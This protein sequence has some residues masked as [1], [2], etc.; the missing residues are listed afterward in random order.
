MAIISIK[1]NNISNI[2]HTRKIGVVCHDAGGAE[3]LSS[4][5]KQNNINSN[6]C[7]DGPAIDIF[8]KIGNI[9]VNNLE[10]VINNSDLILCGTSW[11]SD[12]EWNAIYKANKVRK[13]ISIIDHWVNYRGRYMRNGLI[14][15]PTEIWV[16]DSYAYKIATEIFPSI[17]IKKIINPY[18]LDIKIDWHNLKNMNKINDSKNDVLFISDNI[19]NSLQK[20]YGN[21][22]YWGYTDSDSFSF[23]MS[24]IEKIHP[25][26]TNVSI[27]LHPSEN[28][29]NYTWAL[30]KYTP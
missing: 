15:Y 18:L 11:Q 13:T 10:A 7:L 28:V 19:K 20:Q 17:V 24:H 29:N 27:R 3:I 23:M 26:I 4:Y 5:I 22:N 12:L 8:K 25:K 30:K 14:N 6:Y 21:G 9:L 1:N 16:C 2:K